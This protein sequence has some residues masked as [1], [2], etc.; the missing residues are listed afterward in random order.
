MAPTAP[1]GHYSQPSWQRAPVAGVVICGPP[2]GPRRFIS[3]FGRCTNIPTQL[4]RLLLLN[5]LAA[6]NLRPCVGSSTVATR[7]LSKRVC[8]LRQR[9][10]KA[11]QSGAGVRRHTRSTLSFVLNGARAGASA[12]RTADNHHQLIYGFA[13]RS[14]SS[15]QNS[16]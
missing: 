4:R 12:T 14:S 2:A 13:G 15:R 9:R 1:A 16:D 11:T 6:C 8:K 7:L 5:G 3:T 10:V